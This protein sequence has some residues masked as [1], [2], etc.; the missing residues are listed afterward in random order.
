MRSTTSKEPPGGI[1]L[2]CARYRALGSSGG[3]ASNW[4]ANAN[5][6]AALVMSGAEDGEGGM[7]RAA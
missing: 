2:G 3:G 7:R 6:F 1:Q 4:K 5:L